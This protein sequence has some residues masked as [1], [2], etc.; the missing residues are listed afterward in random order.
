MTC[1]STEEERGSVLKFLSC[2]PSRS[3]TPSESFGAN[4]SRCTDSTETEDTKHLPLDS[5]DEGRVSRLP[6]GRWSGALALVVDEDAAA[7]REGKRESVIGDPE[8]KRGQF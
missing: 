7:K 4:S 2:K 6:R 1:L 8:V 5:R 3:D